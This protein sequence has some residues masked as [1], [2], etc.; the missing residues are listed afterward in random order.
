MR[1]QQSRPSLRVG[2]GFGSKEA[3]REEKMSQS[4]SRSLRM[5]LCQMLSVQKES[6]H[7]VHSQAFVSLTLMRPQSWS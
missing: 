3:K 7:S 4:R 5:R 2:L 1:Y 6:G